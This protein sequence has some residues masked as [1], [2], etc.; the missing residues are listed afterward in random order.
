MNLISVLLMLGF[1]FLQTGNFPS[2]G[3]SNLEGKQFNFPRD[4]AGK[5]NVLAI[6]FNEPERIQAISWRPAAVRLRQAFPEFQ[7]YEMPV[8]PQI[9]SSPRA[10]VDTGLRS[11]VPNVVLP[12]VVIRL[13]VHQD[14]FLQAI[15]E[16]K[17][18]TI[19][20]LVNQ[21]GD[22]LW[23]GYGLH[24]S[25]QEESLKNVLSK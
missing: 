8:L 3:G 4:F 11:G 18:Q 23:R 2:I 15:G 13:Y 9:Y 20:L 12:E 22:I 10:V 6:S 24:T 19:L 17:A 14:K 7:F 5:L 1:S 16:S 25:A 21:Q